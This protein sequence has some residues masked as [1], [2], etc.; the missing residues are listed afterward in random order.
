MFT[1]SYAGTVVVALICGAVWDVT[2]T[3]RAAFAPIAA[4]T[5]LMIVLPPMINFERR[6]GVADQ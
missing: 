4:A 1:I 6:L 3:A 2:G 5:L